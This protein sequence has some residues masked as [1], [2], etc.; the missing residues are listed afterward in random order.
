M[1]INFLTN[2]MKYGPGKPIEIHREYFPKAEGQ[3]DSRLSRLLNYQDGKLEGEQTSFYSNG[4]KEAVMTYHDGIL[5]GL[6]ALWDK[7]GELLEEAHY[8]QGNLHGKYYLLQADGREI[9]SHYKD[10]KLDGLHQIYYPSDEEGVH[11]KE[12]EATFFEGLL[13]EGIM[14]EGL[15]R[16]A[17]ID[18]NDYFSQ[19]IQVG[20]DLVGNVTVEAAE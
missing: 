18:K 7:E 9:V 10:N 17:K 3:S 11:I 14:L 4:G 20:H 6:K 13:P 8:E 16:Y 5:D 1:I 15:L 12:M 19:L 2:A